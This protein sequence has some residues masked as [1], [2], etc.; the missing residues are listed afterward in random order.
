MIAIRCLDDTRHLTIL[1]RECHVLE[2]LNQLSTLHKRQ[3]STLTG[4]ARILT[5]LFG[6]FSKIG[7]LLQSV[8]NRIN[9]N[10]G[11]LMFIR[12]SFLVN[13]Q[14]D[15]GGLHQ[16]VRT[17]LLDCVVIDVVSLL[18]HI[19]IGHHGWQYLLV[20]ILSKLILERSE[21]VI[22]SIEGSSHLQFV[23]DEEIDIFVD[24]FLVDDTFGIIFII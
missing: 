4:R 17:N 5:Y 3:Q 6:H 18:H 13:T 10:F 23:I 15:M 9:A 12:G 22:F 1:Q 14:Q 20:T 21:R 19:V 16:S 2:L 8:I 11:C 7:S 24:G